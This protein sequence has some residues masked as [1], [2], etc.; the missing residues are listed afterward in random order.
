MAEFSVMA[1]KLKG[2]AEEISSISGSMSKC[3]SKVRQ[4]CGSLSL[5]G[6]AGTAVRRNL[7]ELSSGI[8]KQSNKIKKASSTLNQIA[9]LYETTEK[10]I[11]GAKFETGNSE[12]SLSTGSSGSGESGTTAD[13]TKT[14]INSM[15]KFYKSL[16]A[17]LGKVTDDSVLKFLKPIFGYMG[18]FFSFFSDIFGGGSDV[19]GTSADLCD[20][21]K[22]SINLW[23][24]I[25]KVLTPDDPQIAKQYKN[26]WGAKVAGAGIVASV[27]GM[28]GKITEA[29][30]NNGTWG[31]KASSWIDAV[32]ESG[33][34]AESIYNLKHL[35]DDTKTKGIYTKEGLWLTFADTCFSVLSQTTKSVDK[36]YQD[37]SW[38]WNDT[39]ATGIDISI[40][41]LNEIASGL[42]FGL[43]TTE[44]VFGM[45]P[46]ELSQGIQNFAGKLGKEIGNFIV[47][48]KR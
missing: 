23:E 22:D 33:D 12:R 7:R 4:I 38:D 30:G 42:T 19:Y 5:E 29:I 40:C 41:G 2:N 45:T 34:I 25:Y 28:V 14:F 8:E 18:S 47:R 39:A 24:G 15:L 10:Q 9:N 35:A 6:V 26:L 43:V 20:L 46:E 44:S 21:G 32:G 3:G 11:T 27:I 37:G 16:F 1:V 13:P 31:E 17:A 36:Y 48:M